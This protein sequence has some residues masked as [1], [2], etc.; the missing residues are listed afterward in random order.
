[1]QTFQIIA[2]AIVQILLF[3]L[4]N[5][6]IVKKKPI[7]LLF[8]VVLVSPSVALFDTD[9]VVLKQPL[10]ILIILFSYTHLFLFSK[11]FRK[12]HLTKPFFSIFKYVTII[13]MIIISFSIFKYFYKGY[14]SLISH[15]EFIL[16]LLS[17]F[18]FFALFYYYTLNLKEELLLNSISKVLQFFILF[19]S[20]L[21][22]FSYVN[23]DFIRNF[24]FNYY[25]FIVAREGFS[26][27]PL[28]P[29]QIDLKRSV[30]ST[31]SSQNQFGSFASLSLLICTFLYKSNY[32][33]KFQYYIIIALL[34]VIVITSESRTA[35]I[36]FALLVILILFKQY[37]IKI[38]LF[39]PLLI[40]FGILLFPF[41]GER[42]YLLFSSSD[43]IFELGYK[44]RFIFWQLFLESVF[45][46]GS[47]LIIGL[48][49]SN[50]LI[51]FFESGYL[52]MIA[53]GG[54]IGLYFYLIILI[55]PL[56]YLNRK[57]NANTFYLKYFIILLLF[58]EISQ[59]VW[60]SFRMNFFSAI[61]FSII[62]FESTPKSENEYY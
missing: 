41:L 6:R 50:N 62:L 8:V 25:N 23:I 34:I 31:F 13:L 7:L 32:I 10:S 52:N 4:L 15:R 24:H 11:K 30:F 56:K 47:I 18:C 3:S 61:V 54:L 46:D 37:K 22:L 35:L 60:L 43:E 48:N 16:M 45:G 49:K 40:L 12:M 42:T 2:I 36:V 1:M 59:G 39:V 55:Y 27:F 38:I 26:D 5:F 9:F 33:L 57:K 19:T 20:L 44:Q 29:P 14:G 21:A 28:L 53:R 17:F 51:S 58:L